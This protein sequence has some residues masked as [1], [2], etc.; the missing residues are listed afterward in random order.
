VFFRK[1]LKKIGTDR[2]IVF[3]EKSKNRFT[4]THSNSEK[5]TSSSRRL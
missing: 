4:P 5:M 2:L 1:I 3:R